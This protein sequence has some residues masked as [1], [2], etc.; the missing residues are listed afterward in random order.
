MCRELP[1][2][3][4]AS[5]GEP[6]VRGDVEQIS[7]RLPAGPAESRGEPSILIATCEQP[8]RGVKIHAR[9]APPDTGPMP[10]PRSI[11]GWFTTEVGPP[12]SI[13]GRSQH[14]IGRSAA[15]R[16]EPLLRS[17]TG[18]R[19]STFGKRLRWSCPETHNCMCRE[20]WGTQSTN[21]TAT[22]SQWPS[23]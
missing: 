7:I 2:R 12:R 14:F 3:P 13:A 6:I 21:Q 16:S 20:L 4:A 8:D 5:R 17:S 1:A 22:A 10:I 19:S 11:T 18:G 9:P 15:S 23:I